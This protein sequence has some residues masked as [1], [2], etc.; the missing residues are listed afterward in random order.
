MLHPDAEGA[1]DSQLC[2]VAKQAILD[3]MEGLEVRTT[4]ALAQLLGMNR[5]RLRATIKA[6]GIEEEYQEI[7]KKGRRRT[8]MLKT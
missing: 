6:L 1:F 3:G 2:A 7:R 8:P 4:V 5:D